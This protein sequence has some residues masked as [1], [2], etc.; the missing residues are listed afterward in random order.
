M[1]PG[2][3]RKA[4]TENPWKSI[5][6]SE[7]KDRLEKNELIYRAKAILM[8]RYNIIEKEALERLQK[9]SQNQRKKMKEIAQA[10]ITSRSILT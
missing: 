3:K 6:F 7:L 10:V 5:R 8:D 9:E 1:P 2:V 4:A